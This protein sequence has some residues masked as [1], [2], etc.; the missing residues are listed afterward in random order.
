MFPS[1]PG[2]GRG[3]LARRQSSFQKSSAPPRPPPTPPRLLA[4][5]AQADPV[6]DA[7][8][9]SP[10]RRRRRFAPRLVRCRHV[11][12]SP[13]VVVPPAACRRVAKPTVE[14]DESGPP[15]GGIAVG[16][17]GASR[18]RGHT[19]MVV[20]RWRSARRPLGRCCWGVCAAA[21]ARSGVGGL[22]LCRAHVGGGGV[23]PP[24]PGRYPSAG[25]AAAAEADTNRSGQRGR[26]AYGFYATARRAADIHVVHIRQTGP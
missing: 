21:V 18:P 20:Q 13:A 11:G 2:P 14:V 24:T 15:A 22:R 1:W 23:P 9:C 5:V 16:C 6:P 8:R 7:V 4:T 17:G 25:P 19:E 12:G 3:W 10:T 26:H